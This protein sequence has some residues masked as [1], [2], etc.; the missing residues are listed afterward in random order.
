MDVYAG[1]RAD[2]L[3]DDFQ[4]YV[5]EVERLSFLQLLVDTTVGF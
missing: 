1:V 2:V 5:Y 3:D 4:V